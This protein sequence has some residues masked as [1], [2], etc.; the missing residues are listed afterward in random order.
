MID[1]RYHLVSLVAVFIALAVGIVLGAGPLREGISDTIDEEVGQ[2][3]TERTEL[4]TELDVRARQAEA[5]DEAVDLLSPRGVAGTLNG[6]RVAL[7][8]LPGADRNHVALLEDRVAEAG[9]AL[10]LE[11][12]VDDSLDAGEVDEAVVDRLASTVEV[13]EVRGLDQTGL[14][15][16][17]GATLAGSD[18]DGD[19]GAWLASAEQLEEEGLLD[20]RWQGQA[21]Q[22]T[23]RRPPDAMVV[24]GGGLPEGD[25]DAAPEAETRLS[26]RL[27]LVRTLAALEQPLVVGAAGTE[28]NAL[29]DGGGEDAL[30]Q[31]IRDEG[32]LRDEVST[33]DDLESASGRAAAVLGLA[34]ELQGEAGHYGL[35]RQAEAPV[36]APPPLR[37]GVIPGTDGQAPAGEPVPDDA[38]TTSAP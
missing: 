13:P 30:V 6:T 32:D 17:L 20:L 25:D 14:G 15:A 23:D 9:G 12:E 38:E 36:P 24:V 22:V 7:V 37:L 3:R 18:P 1:F 10:V 8:V 2:L 35:G 21:A 19:V 34:W 26:T 31:A 28:T 33:V 11:V 29:A 4:R 16:L 5:K 27:D